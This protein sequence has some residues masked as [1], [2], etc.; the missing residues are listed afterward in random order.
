MKRIFNIKYNLKPM[1][2]T[3]IFM[4]V[5]ACTLLVN[6]LLI[7]TVDAAA[8]E[9]NTSSSS[10]SNSFSDK[11]FITD[12]SFSGIADLI[13][14]VDNRYQVDE[15]EFVPKEESKQASGTGSGSSW[16]TYKYAGTT[17]YLS[18]SGGSDNPTMSYSDSDGFTG[19]LN[20]TGSTL[21]GT[22]GSPPSNPQPGDTYTVTKTYSATYSGTVT[23][24]VQQWKEKWVTYGSYDAA[25]KAYLYTVETKVMALGYPENC[26]CDLDPVNIMTGNF[27]L[28]ESDMTLA[29]RG[30]SIDVKRYYNSLDPEVNSLGKGWRF[31]YESKIEKKDD[32]L[33]VTYPHGRKIYF[34]QEGDSNVYKAPLTVFD[35]L[36][37]NAN[38]TYTLTTADQTVYQ[39]NSSGQLL[40]ITDINNN[41]LQLTYS[42]G[43][44]VG[45][46]GP[47]GKEIRITMQAGKIAQ[48]QDPLGRIIKYEYDS[49]NRLT[50][51]VGLGGTTIYSYNQ[52]GITSIIDANNHKQ[53]ENV[54]DQ[55]GRVIQQTDAEGNVSNISYNDAERINTVLRSA[56]GQ[57]ISYSYN[58]DLFVTKEMYADGSYKSYSYDEH[59]NVATLRERNGAV[60]S[61][62]Y[63][64]R[65]N[66]IRIVSPQPFQ[67]ETLMSYND[68]NQV[69]QI[70]NSDGGQINF[71]YD[72]HG[73]L[74]E[75]Q[76]KIDDKGTIASTKYTYDQYGR[77]LSMTDAENRRISYVYDS[78]KDPIKVIDAE[79]NEIR[80]SYDQAG[81]RVTQTNIDGTTTYAY[82]A[83][84]Q[85]ITVTD[86]TQ[87]I[88]RMKY[89]GMGNLIK[90]I[91][92]EYYNAST[93]DGLGTTFAYNK[94]KQM[95]KTVDPLGNIYAYQYDEYGNATK[96]IAPNQYDAT[97][98]DGVGIK[99]EYDTNNN[100][101]RKIYPSGKQARFKYDSVGNLIKFIQPEQY[102]ASTDDGIGITYTYDSM[103]RLVE[104]RDGRGNVL[105]RYVYDSMNRVIKEMDAEGY[106]SGADD[107][108]RIGTIYTYNYAGAL[109]ESR[110][111]L[112]QQKGVTYYRVTAYQY[113]RTG[114]LLEQ[115]TSSEEVTLT[116]APASWNIISYQYN[117]LG[118]TTEIRDSLGSQII[119]TYD[120]LGRVVQEKSKIND[121]TYRTAGYQYNAAGLL[122][123]Q[124]LSV[125]GKDVDS[126][127]PLEQLETQY[128]YNKN[129]QLIKVITPSGNVTTYT[130]D[131]AGRK[132][133]E[134]KKVQVDS[135]KET[136]V[137]ALVTSSR[138]F[139]YPGQTYSLDVVIDP[140]KQVS[141]FTI[142][143]SYDARIFELVEV[144]PKWTGLSESHD[145][146]GRIQFVG[147][148]AGIK[149]RTSIATIQLKV[150]NNISGIAS[151]L[152]EPD[153]VYVDS[154]GVSKSF[155][156]G[157]GHSFQLQGPDM[158]RD[159]SVETNDVTFNAK[160][161]GI[162]YLN[163]LFDSKFDINDSKA[164]DQADMD[165]I[166]DWLFHNKS[167]QLTTL[168]YLK[169][170]QSYAQMDV[171]FAQQEATRSVQL[172]YDKNGN[173]VQVT[174]NEGRTIAYTYDILNRLTSVKDEEGAVTRYSYD[175][176]NNI[177]KEIRPQHSVAGGS[178]KGTS[179]V[180]DEMNRL[181]TTKNEEGTVVEHLVYDLQGRI[182]KQIDASGY[183]S[184]S[185]DSSRYGMIYTYDLADRVLTIATPEAVRKN[186]L[187]LRYEY[188]AQDYVLREVD[189]E[190]NTTTY[191]RDMWGR[192]TEVIDAEGNTTRYS[193]DYA[194]N[195]A[196]STDAKGNQT[197]YG[198]NS[199]NALESIVDPL[200]QSIRYVYDVEGRVSSITDRN[201]L[202]TTFS[203][204]SDNQI[205]EE[206]VVQT[207]EYKKFLYG[208]DGRIT[209]SAN[210]EM[211][212]QYRYNQRGQLIQH[213]R[214]GKELVNYA[215]NLDGQLQTIS[216]ALGSQTAYN[217]DD[218]GRLQSVQDKGEL[219]ATYHYN[220]ND[221]LADVTYA[222]GDKTTYGYD[223]DGNVTSL[224][225]TNKQG[226][227]YNRYSYSYDGNRNLVAEMNNGN[228]TSYTYN[229]LQQL[230]AVQY[231]SYS[232]SF[233]YDASGNRIIEVNK[234]VETHYT[235][236]ANNRLTQV[237]SNGSTENYHYDGNGNTTRIERTGGSVINYAF[238]GFNQL[239]QSTMDDG[240]W[241]SYHYDPYDGLRTSISENGLQT[242]FIYDSR[243]LGEVI[244]E[245]TASGQ[246][247]SSTIRGLG[248]LAQR[249]PQG[250][251]YNYLFNAHGDVTG[252][253][254]S[255]GKLVNSYT[256]D[257]FG[258][259]TNSKELIANRY[260][261]SGEQL[262]PVTS[263]YYLRARYYSPE[264]GR[265]SQEDTYRGD[266]LN[267]YTYVHNNPVNYND[268]TGHQAHTTLMSESGGAYKEDW[269]KSNFKGVDIGPVQL[270]EYWIDV[271]REYDTRAAKLIDRDYMYTLFYEEAFGIVVGEKSV[272][273]GTKGKTNF[274]YYYY[275]AVNVD[276]NVC[277][278]DSD[279]AKKRLKNAM[280]F[281][282]LETVNS[283]AFGGLTGSGLS[284]NYSGKTYATS[285]K[286]MTV[287]KS[288]PSTNPCNCFT[289]GTKVLTDEGEKNIEDIEVGDKVLAKSEYDS[290]GGLSYKE[291]TALYRNQ[292]DDII[293]LHVGEQVIETTDNHPFWVEG[294]GWV[295]ADELQVGDKLQR[296]DGSNLTIDKVEFVKLDEPVTVYNFTVADYHTYYVTDLG[297][298]VHNTNC[299][300]TGKDITFSDKFSKPAYKNQVADRGWTN[301]SIAKAIN[302]PVKTGK[303]KNPYTGNEVTLYYVNN[304]HY[305]AVDKGTGKVIQVADLNKADWKMD[306]T[307]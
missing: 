36:I 235:Y 301:D 188:D 207:G 294:K 242:N 173:L 150:K 45:I 47:G 156:E 137:R 214:N 13:R 28:S 264:L 306:L 223:R 300:L 163:P 87:A 66:T 302:N 162:D 91:A 64:E 15:G 125:T 274:D 281:D 177:I 72:T 286:G 216:S 96:E 233:Q 8:K 203:Y 118:Q 4:I 170:D 134:Q 59:G 18:S 19:T 58:D 70:V 265:F 243:G 201:G 142:N 145:A 202:E 92:P 229:R 200:G 48:V 166:T 185:S 78:G 54:Y 88:S 101:I 7:P 65:G 132:T 69:T 17:W 73:N 154:T 176:N 232:E 296:A 239:T 261:Y 282:N 158:N 75:Q 86:P 105:N 205:T 143:T 31:E 24:T 107:N 270:L 249:D 38:Q 108:S 140:D 251:V 160:Q 35:V 114:K 230:V 23:R 198:Y 30:M 297:I 192:A 44:L 83:M 80:Y 123:K 227:N 164:V 182:V 211:V 126:D 128:F 165:Y 195:L 16:A 267:L 266:G 130:Y 260:G 226:S 193:Y 81:R 68:D 115:R 291:V 219:V 224:T 241:M 127:K 298:W 218:T 111:P 183:A 255:Q 161:Q 109:V 22:S 287:T 221:M 25:Y 6:G 99:Y 168:P 252:I 225:S 307:K 215:Y 236:D 117:Q 155:T 89:D 159:G 42:S 74:I 179:Y 268:P 197:V 303:S 231:P 82:N 284:F 285:N 220:T 259:I 26:V 189:G 245:T 288:K 181:L 194:G 293:K 135:L 56:S 49:S 1:L 62:S 138:Q 256:Y 33:V 139:I 84:D 85:I 172:T 217:Y 136:H 94:L 46:V 52:Y 71:L 53:V 116:Q 283:I 180:Y 40:S 292:R 199:M 103:N 61:Y 11:K 254:D 171:Q 234:G 93:D 10:S 304:V 295:F 34:A 222:N 157:I 102:I 279:F 100:L 20:K 187:T 273:A 191:T 12:G 152:I 2:V 9:S 141:G 43:S 98:G 237:N 122:A 196:S 77:L 67:Y 133:A 258:E 112:R 76:V 32:R 174:D 262:D 50:K 272:F 104:V 37:K 149:E 178:G 280:Y 120:G 90:A 209:A 257:A 106:K 131:A 175:E 79:G 3:T 228:K 153:S 250:R 60:R 240:S 124:W 184:G 289:A 186:A 238:N 271:V 204:N 97:S 14:V 275:L 146:V 55:F 51:V 110:E 276:G 29:D 248:L 39:Y 208:R 269:E 299:S 121:S 247:L 210:N 95:V 246:P 290:R 263:E 144:T 151:V 21:T 305:V 5:V 57:R 190:G 212:N 206:K 41:T 119:Y 148:G 278:A 213:K 129:K 253:S 167:E 169:Y 277:E 27:I 147:S 63:D 244:G 113:D